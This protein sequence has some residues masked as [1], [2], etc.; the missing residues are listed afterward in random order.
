M[1]A[2]IDNKIVRI[3][4][5]EIVGLDLKT[6]KEAVDAGLKD[7]RCRSEWEEF[8]STATWILLH[9][10]SQ[11]W[12]LRMIPWMLKTGRGLGRNDS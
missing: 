2:E 12:V 4:Y 1:L 3:P 9:I 6:F 8:L 7:E 5:H 11:K 10:P